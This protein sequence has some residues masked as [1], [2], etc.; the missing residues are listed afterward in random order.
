[1]NAIKDDTDGMQDHALVALNSQSTEVKQVLR[2]ISPLVH[3]CNATEQKEFSISTKDFAEANGIDVSTAYKQ[4]E[5]AAMNLITSYFD[6]I[7][8]DGNLI[9]TNFVIRIMY[10][11]AEFIFFFTEEML[12]ALST[13]HKNTL[14]LGAS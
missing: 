3:G 4:L 9:Q 1:M 8:A 12:F 7:N 11:E 14:A 10:D 2:A 13:W 5:T 6:Y